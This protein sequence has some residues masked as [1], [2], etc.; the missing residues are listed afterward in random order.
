[1]VTN[2]DEMVHVEYNIMNAPILLSY[3]W[4]DRHAEAKSSKFVTFVNSR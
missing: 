4:I 1:M 2:C 3:R